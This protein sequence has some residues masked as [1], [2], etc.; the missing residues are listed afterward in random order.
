[1]YPL[2]SVMGLTAAKDGYEDYI[3]HLADESLNGSLCWVYAANVNLHFPKDPLT[4][5]LEIEEVFGSLPKDFIGWRQA[6]RENVRPG[7]LVLLL[8][9]DPVPADMVILSSSSKEG[10]VFVSTK[11]LDG[12]TNLKRREAIPPAQD[13]SMPRSCL[14]HSFIVEYEQPNSN[15]Y[16]FRGTLLVTK[17][18][19][20]LGKIYSSTVN[21]PITAS[22]VLLAG[23]FLVNTKWVVGV[24]VGVGIESKMVLNSTQAKKKTSKIE[25]ILNNMVKCNFVFLT[26]FSFI[27]LNETAFVKNWTSQFVC[28]NESCTLDNPLVEYFLGLTMIQGLIPLALYLTVDIVRAFQAYFINQDIDLYDEET[29]ERCNPKNWNIIEDLGQIEY[30]FSDKTGTLTQNKMDFVRCSVNGSI[31]GQTFTD[32]SARQSNMTVREQVMFQASRRGSF[33]TKQNTVMENSY[34]SDEVPFYDKYFFDDF[35]IHAKRQ[36]LT[37]FFTLLAICHSIP[38]PETHVT[39]KL[40]YFGESPDEVAFITAAKNI[41][42]VFLGRFGDTLSLMVF[43]QPVKYTCLSTLDYSSSR[44][45]MSVI[46]KNEQNEIILM[47]KG[48][49]EYL[50]N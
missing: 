42:I 3:R 44:K 34:R 2:V 36:E 20:R 14:K 1:M 29:N 19:T 10:A 48:A 46:V 13:N 22:N 39:E 12:E 41:G 45:R 23:S 18:E 6:K 16:I 31:Y 25:G 7:D 35:L 28:L 26:L 5:T 40:I 21:C 32:V 8:N 11:G 15:L 17:H 38:T 33:L 47:T 9:N 27:T 50:K 43:G 30:I 4:K 37:K 24:V 49:D